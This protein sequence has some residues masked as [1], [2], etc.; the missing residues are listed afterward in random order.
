VSAGFDAHRDDPLASMGLT[1]EGYAELTA[2]VAGIAK[3]HCRGR[4]LSSLEGGYNLTALAASVERHVQALVGV[5]TRWLKWG[6]GVA[7]LAGAVYLY[8][9]EVKPVVIFGLRPEYAHAIPFQKIPEGL[10]SLKAE[11]CGQ[12]HREIYEEWK[13]SIHAQAYEDP[14]FSSLL[15]ERQEYLDLFELPYAAGKPAADAGEG[16]STWTCGEGSTG[17]EPPLRCR[18]AKGVD[19]LCGLSCAGR[20]DSG[21]VRRFR[22]AASDEISIRVSATRNSVRAATMSCRDPRS[23]TM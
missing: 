16:H 3:Q 13:T 11:S 1:E 12:C 19:H 18:A 14:F 17:A 9:T 7:V 5:M 4:L 23:F 22:R 15:E 10:T 20:G 2:I 8:Y 21:A 6:L